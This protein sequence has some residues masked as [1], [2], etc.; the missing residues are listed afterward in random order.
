MQTRPTPT[1]PICYHE[2]YNKYFP[3]LYRFALKFTLKKTVSK[4]LAQ[5]TLNQFWENW[6]HNNKKNRESKHTCLKQSKM[7]L[8]TII[9]KKKYYNVVL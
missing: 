4:E 2:I 3:I 5:N 1:S 8:I 9:E 6:K 7:K